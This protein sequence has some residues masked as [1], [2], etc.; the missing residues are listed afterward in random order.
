MPERIADFG[1]ALITAANRQPLYRSERMERLWKNEGATRRHGSMVSSPENCLDK[2]N[3]VATACHRSPPKSH[4][5]ECH[6]EGP[7]R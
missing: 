5:K 1:A 4:G 6:E 7:P 2:P 3:L